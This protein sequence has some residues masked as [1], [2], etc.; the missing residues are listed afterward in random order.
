MPAPPPQVFCLS[1]N[2]NNRLSQVFSVSCFNLLF[3]AAQATPLSSV[4]EAN[5]VVCSCVKSRDQKVHWC[6]CAQD[7]AC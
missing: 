1:L 3:Q 5:S 6:L 4:L 2:A 7:G